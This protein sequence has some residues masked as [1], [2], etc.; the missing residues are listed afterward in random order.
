M[1]YLPRMME[2]LSIGYAIKIVGIVNNLEEKAS[3]RTFFLPNSVLD[4]VLVLNFIFIFTSYQPT[5]L[6]FVRS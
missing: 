3:K 2:A 4:P 5:L 6:I 1:I